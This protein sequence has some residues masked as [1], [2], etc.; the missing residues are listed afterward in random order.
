[1]VTTLPRLAPHL[2]FMSADLRARLKPLC[3]KV[4][5][6]FPKLPPLRLLCFFDNEELEQLQ[7]QGYFIGISAGTTGIHTPVLGGGTWPHHV[8]KYFFD[9]HAEQFA[10]DDLIYIPQSRY[11]QAKVSFVIIFAHELQHFVQ[12]GLV[13][14]I[15]EA[16]R[17]LLWNLAKFDPN[18][19]LKP[20]S[21]PDNREAMI[22][23]K[24]VAEAVCGTEAVRDFVAAQIVDGKNNNNVSKAHLWMW[25]QTLTP[26]TPYNLLKE[27]DL[28]VQKYKLQ[29]QQLKSDID[30]STVKWWL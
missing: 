11:A 12:R 2:E 29:L 10:F 7:H 1:M 15:A 5:R 14:R 30:F 27:T 20:W 21:L 24:R 16:N 17:L 28:L 26:S 19:E 13:P 4:L 23:A 9:S 22:V 25:V 6:E 18:T 3:D 8:S